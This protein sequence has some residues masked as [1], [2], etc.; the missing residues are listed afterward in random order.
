MS[1]IFV[2]SLTSEVQE[3]A[4][5]TR[6]ARENNATLLPGTARRRSGS[7][8]GSASGDKVVI[9]AHGSATALGTSSDAVTYTPA[10]LAASLVDDLHINDRVKVILAACDSNQFAASL[11]A[12]IRARQ[13]HTHVECVGQR[14]S[15]VFPVNFHP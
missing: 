3:N 13:G 10:D 11:Q 2:W 14:G 7:L 1:Q 4:N 15:F 12:L 8:S 9:V 6:W 5:A